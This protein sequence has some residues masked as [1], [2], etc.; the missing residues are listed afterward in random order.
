MAVKAVGVLL[1]G[2][3]K[4]SCVIDLLDCSVMPLLFF[5]PR[6]LL[7]QTSYDTFYEYDATRQTE[8]EKR[9]HA[10]LK[11]INGTW[12]LTTT[13]DVESEG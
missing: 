8:A 6:E 2:N 13:G 10:F 9:I 7:R 5:Y 11:H 1:L 3:V 12:A 4:M